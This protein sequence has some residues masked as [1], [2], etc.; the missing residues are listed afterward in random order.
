MLRK[1]QAVIQ[2]LELTSSDEIEHL[3]KPFTS[4]NGGIETTYT[5]RTMLNE[6]QWPILSEQGKRQTNLFHTMDWAAEGRDRANQV[7]FT[8]YYDR[9]EFVQKFV[10]VLPAYAKWFFNDDPGV[11]QAWFSPHCDPVQATFHTDDAGNWNGQWTTTD[12]EMQQDLFD[13]DMGV[14]IKFDNI[15][16]VNETSRRILQVDDASVRTFGLGAQGPAPETDDESSVGASSVGASSAAA[17][18]VSEGSAMS[19]E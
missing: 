10:R 7:Y 16:M 14:T 5:L 1:H 17:S 6:L 18:A 13:E 11:I 15:E 3:D 9:H 4:Y 12:D 8:A 19:D 2:S